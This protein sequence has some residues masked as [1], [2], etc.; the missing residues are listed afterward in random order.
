LKLKLKLQLNFNRSAAAPAGTAAMRAG[1]SHI[2]IDLRANGTDVLF[3][4]VWG[5]RPN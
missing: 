1:R 4:T 3:T 5:R 2:C